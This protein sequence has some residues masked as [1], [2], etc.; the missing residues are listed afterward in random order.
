MTD[1]LTPR[2]IEILALIAEGLTNEEIGRRLVIAR[3]TVKAHSHNIYHKLGVTTRTQALLKAGEIGLLDAPPITS[4]S[5]PRRPAAELAPFIGRDAELA[6]LAA[7]LADARIRLI[8]ILGAGGMGKSRLALAL[9]DEH[10]GAFADGVHLVTLAQ[11]S[12]AGQVV[13]ALIEALGLRLQASDP[14]EGQLFGFLRDKKLLLV[15]D[16][17][18]HVGEAADLV[19]DILSAAPGVRALVTSRARLNLG[20]EVVFVLGGLAFTDEADADSPPDHAAAHLLLE[21]AARMDPTFAPGP[22]DWPAIRRICRLTEGMPLALILAAGWLELLTL[23]EIAEE[24]AHSIDILESQ[25][26]D[27]PPRQRSMRAAIESSWERLTADERRVCAA[28]AVM[29]GGFTREAAAVVAGASLRHLQTLV[30][31]SFITFD[32]GRYQMHELLRQFA[33]EALNADAEAAG[34]IHHRHSDYYAAFLAERFE[35][36]V[37]GSRPGVIAEISAD[38]DNI[39]AAWAWALNHLRLASLAAMAQPLA[40]LF[41]YQS[42]YLE[43][44]RLFEQAIDQLSAAPAGPDRDRALATLMEDLGYYYIRVG[45]VADSEA[46]LRRAQTHQDLIGYLPPIST[47][48]P[49][50]GLSLCA[51]IRGDHAEAVALAVQALE[52]H[53]R[54]GHL[55]HQ[56]YALYALAGIAHD[57]GQYERAL[58]CAERAVAAAER[59]RDRWLL[60]HCRFQ[61]GQVLHGMDQPAEAEPHYRASYAIYSDFGDLGGVAAALDRLGQ[62]ALKRGDWAE[63][64]R[65]Y[66]E[67]C[68][69]YRRIHDQ[70]GM[71]AALQGLAGVA[72]GRGDHAACRDHLR[73]AL[74]LGGAMHYV[75]LLFAAL[76]TTVELSLETGDDAFALGLLRFI[77]DHPACNQQVKDRARQRI[78]AHPLGDAFPARPGDL[79]AQVAAAQAA[80]GGDHPPE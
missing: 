24:L 49:L 2:E 45:R 21:R 40:A 7:M 20:A 10:A 33:Q 12:D 68:I 64:D 32:A 6:R 1:A 5:A 29:R 65:H 58:D 3:G 43:G 72:L 14:P 63:A 4:E 55:T 18:E 17:F 28:L 31:R 51:S 79:A 39:R 9:A 37:I 23:D 38:L 25:L 56:A 62:I 66:N 78:R 77:A 48:D 46:M 73:R 15:L 30:N 44:I 8:T 16:N 75:P 50:I 70:G 54:T 61:L 69:T 11:I 57:Q 27:L 47:T 19:R 41:H 42:R 53:T 35:A 36:M 71:A 59:A 74:A 76:L 34:R 52:K 60:A 67:S 22:A 13:Y 26:R 80:L